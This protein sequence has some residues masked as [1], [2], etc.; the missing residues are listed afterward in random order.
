MQNAKITY[1]SCGKDALH[2]VIS[3]HLL[4]FCRH[5]NI[6]HQYQADLASV[7]GDY[8]HDV[9]SACHFIFCESINHCC[10]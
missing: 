7:A 1:I 5:I 10:L 6:G 3:M 8:G 4:M 9:C 2:C